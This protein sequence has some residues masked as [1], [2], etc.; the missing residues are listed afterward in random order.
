MFGTN[1]ETPVEIV[2]KIRGFVTWIDLEKTFKAQNRSLAIEKFN[3][4]FKKDQK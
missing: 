1:F 2:K 4:F 3:F